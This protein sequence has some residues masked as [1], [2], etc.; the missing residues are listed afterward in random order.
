MS[1]LRQKL[2]QFKPRKRCF[3]INKTEFSFW[4]SLFET[5]SMFSWNQTRN[6]CVIYKAKNANDGVQL[7][8]QE[9]LLCQTQKKG[10]LF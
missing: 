10:V 7:K 4:Q 6:E 8:N 2:S 1:I 9:D 5:P 3:T